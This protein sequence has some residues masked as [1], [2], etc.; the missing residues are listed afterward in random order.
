MAK[1]QSNSG[2]SGGGRTGGARGQGEKMASGARGGR[3]GRGETGGGFKSRGRAAVAEASIA[4]LPVAKNDEVV[5]DIIGMNHDGEGVGRAE[6]YTLF[7]AGAL[8]GEKAR[9][10]VLKTKSSMATPNCWMWLRQARTGWPRPVD[11]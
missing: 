5:L 10:K 3:G 2:R 7:V 8:P 9:V 4:G 6:G 11:L 1:R